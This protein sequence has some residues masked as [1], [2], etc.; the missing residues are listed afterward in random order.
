MHESEFSSSGFV[1]VFHLGQVFKRESIYLV[2]GRKISSI[3][4]F[5]YEI[6]FF[7]Y[8]FG[9]SFQTNWNEVTELDIL[10]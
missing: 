5:I 10:P 9:C 4:I 8:V 6:T 1:F 2:Q 3:F 7:Q